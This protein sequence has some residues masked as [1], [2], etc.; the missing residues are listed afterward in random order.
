MCTS[1]SANADG[2]RDAASRKVDHI[3][4]HNEC[5]LNYQAA[6]FASDI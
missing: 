1:I 2:W 4:L 6:I 5:R 3:A